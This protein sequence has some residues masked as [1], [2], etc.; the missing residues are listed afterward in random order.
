MKQWYE[1]RAA[2]KEKRAEIWVYEEIG[3]NFWGEGVTAKQFV[4]D[5]AALDV[6]AIDLHVN[7]PGGNVWDGTAIHN[8]LVRHPAAVTTYIDG[9]A[10]SIATIVALAGERV[11]MAANGLF[12]IHKAFGLAIGNAEEMRDFAGELDDVDSTIASVYAA[13]T[14]MT[15]DEALELMSPELRMKADAAL[16]RGFVDEVA[17]QMAMAASVGERFDLWRASN[18]ATLQH[19]WKSL[20]KTPEDITASSLTEPAVAPAL[21]ATAQDRDRVLIPGVGFKQFNQRKVPR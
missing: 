8:A 19:V 10:A 17:P 9:L 6:D 1:I 21:T 20:G 7:S 5:L 15:E 2:A 12:I 11:I 13:K 18:T 3:E 16:E 14:G 4:K